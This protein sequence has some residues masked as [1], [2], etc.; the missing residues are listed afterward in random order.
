MNI[1]LAQIHQ[2]IHKTWTHQIYVS[3]VGVRVLWDGVDGVQQ[4]N[5]A[6]LDGGGV[7]VLHEFDVCTFD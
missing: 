2:D 5:G 1:Q 3:T 7:G 6:Q 4:E